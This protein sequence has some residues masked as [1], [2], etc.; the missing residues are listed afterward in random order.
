MSRAHLCR[1]VWASTSSGTWAGCT[2]CS[3]TS[4][5]EPI[6]RHYHQNNITFSI[7]YAFSENFMLA[8]SHDEVVHGKG[9]LYPKNAG[10][11]L[12]EVG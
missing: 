2:T 8:L 4:S 10:R 7:W 9:N 11:R 3:T 6:H 1:A 12:A 5:E